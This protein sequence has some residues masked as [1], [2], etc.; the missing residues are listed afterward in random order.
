MLWTRGSI[1]LEREVE[2]TEGWEPRSTSR[3]GC[4]KEHITQTRSRPRDH[5]ACPLDEADTHPPSRQKKAQVT[6]PAEAS[7]YL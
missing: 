7:A 2:S 3:E 4:F 5:H 6:C 1:T